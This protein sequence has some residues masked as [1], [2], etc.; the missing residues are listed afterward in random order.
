MGG[1][2]A[3]ESLHL[4]QGLLA[5]KPNLDCKKHTIFKD[6]SGRSPTWFWIINVEENLSASLEYFTGIDEAVHYF[7]V[8]S[9]R[10]ST[11]LSSFNYLFPANRTLSDSPPN[12]YPHHGA[13][14]YE[15][16][17]DR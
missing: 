16:Q 2:W 10:T 5:K 17:A 15:L 13:S 7:S 12:P 1:R 4:L 9:F 14:T 6:Y 3:G 8:L 11:S